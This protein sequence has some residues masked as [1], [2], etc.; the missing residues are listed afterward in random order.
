ME[1]KGNKLK[2]NNNFKSSC[3]CKKV[4]S[5]ILGEI[6]FFTDIKNSGKMTHFDLQCRSQINVFAY[7]W[8]K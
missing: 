4:V 2:K 8:T 1:N 6:E 7:L 3:E 5:D